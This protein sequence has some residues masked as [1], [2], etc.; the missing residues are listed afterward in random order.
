MVEHQVSTLG[1]AVRFRS[2]A[3][4]VPSDSC[5]T[6]SEM[7][8]RERRRARELRRCEGLPI[9]E[10]AHRLGVSQAS[11]SV[12]VR[13]IELTDEQQQALRSKNPAHNQLLSGRAV[14]AA[15]RRAERTAAQAAGRVLARRAETLHAAGCML[16]WAEGAKGRN[17][18]RFCNSDPQMM[19]VFVQFLRTYFDVRDDDIRVTCHLYADHL[20]RQREVERFWLDVLRLPDSALGKSIV[21]AYSKH[22]ARKRLNV[23]PYGTCRVVVSKTSV[24]QSIYGAIQE[25]AGFERP[26][27]LD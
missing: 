18:V 17:Q 9:K 5:G 7:K 27:W 26:E 25:Y 16:Y 1:T 2:P 19:Q 24:V 4:K 6:L 3:L 23:L 14:A 11:V 22:S 13:D 20:E 15:N 12:W 10:I 21:N 8:T